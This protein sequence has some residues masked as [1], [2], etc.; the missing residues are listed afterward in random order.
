MLDVLGGATMKRCLLVL[1]LSA[2]VLSACVPNSTSAPPVIVQ[3]QD[4]FIIIVTG[5]GLS[6]IDHGT[7]YEVSHEARFT[8]SYMVVKADGNSYSKSVSSITPRSYEISDA[9]MVSCA[10][11]MS[12]GHLE[13][14]RW[15]QVE[16]IKNGISV[17]TV[18]TADRYGM[19]SATGD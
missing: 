5:E 16:I 19:V 15:I 9:S 4:S 14:G 10:F 3:R 13:S 6:F 1:T 2:L 12:P 18:K 17:N 7:S 11:Q 8:G